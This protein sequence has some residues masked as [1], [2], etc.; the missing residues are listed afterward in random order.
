MVQTSDDAI[1]DL[2]FNPEA[3]GLP[4]SSFESSE[5]Q[6]PEDLYDA[7]LLEQ[8][9]TL[10]KEAIAQAEKG[11]T[12]GALKTL[13][14]CIGLEA[15]YASAYNNR[16]QIYRM[17]KEDDLALKDLNHVIDTASNQPKILRQAYTQ[18]AIL[19]RQQGDLAAA[20]RDFEMGAKYGN[21]IART[22]AVRE[23]PYAKMCNQVMMEVMN[24]ELM[25]GIVNDEETKK[26]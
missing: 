21:S 12:D 26:D 25:R 1:L 19:R 3:Q 8:L 13:E 17:R 22:I 5:G 9:R 6:S 11:D 16:A 7:K 14:Q 2:M 18:R 20:Q 23:N 15:T 4:L 10:E 24:R